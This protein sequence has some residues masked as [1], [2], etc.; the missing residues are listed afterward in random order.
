M[1]GH[2]YLDV[3]PSGRRSGAAGSRRV[4]AFA[5]RGGAYHPEIE[6]LENTL[7]AFEH[8]VDLGY[9]YLETDVH[10]TA[11]GV[12]LAFHDRVLDR[13]T[14]SA[15]EVAAL[16]HAEVRRARVGGRESVPSCSMPSPTPG[17]TST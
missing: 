1:T 16:T 12:L 13:V 3:R 6:G 5:H 2:A 10:L 8:A 15:G 9:R 14:D 11:D 17:S 7:V 4:I